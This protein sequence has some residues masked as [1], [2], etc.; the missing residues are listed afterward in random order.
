MVCPCWNIFP[1]Y[2]RRSLGIYL[3]AERWT[4]KMYDQK[5]KLLVSHLTIQ[6]FR[7]LLFEF[8]SGGTNINAHAN[9]T[10][11]LSTVPSE[12]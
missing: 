3:T 5:I 1:C 8:L 7:C 9:V 2:L 6:F 11:H 10:E 4:V 12:W